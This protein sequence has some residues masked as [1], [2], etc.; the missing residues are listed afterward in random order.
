MGAEVYPGDAD[1]QDQEGQKRLDG[2]AKPRPADKNRGQIDEE[3][4]EDEGLVSM[5]AREAKTPKGVI[6][7]D[8]VGGWSGTVN[9]YLKEGSEKQQDQDA[10]GGKALGRPSASS[11]VHHEQA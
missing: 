8:Q 1:S 4:K 3:A 2:S 5:P 9:E 6:D 10:R 7:A 11:P